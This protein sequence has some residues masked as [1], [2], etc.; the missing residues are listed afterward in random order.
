MNIIA[1][2][3]GL[4][5]FRTTALISVRLTPCTIKLEIREIV[6]IIRI[7]KAIGNSLIVQGVADRSKRFGSYCEPFFPREYKDR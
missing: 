3:R 1:V 5:L 2:T 6:I 7:L 4:L